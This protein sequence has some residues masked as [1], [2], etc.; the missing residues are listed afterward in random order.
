MDKKQIQNLWLYSNSLFLLN[1]SLAILSLFVAFP[2]PKLPSFFNNLFLI[3]SYALTFQSLAANIKSQG[4]ATFLTKASSQPNTFCLALFL[5]FIPNILLLPFYV[6]CIYHICSAVLSRKKEFENYF[7]YEICVALGKNLNSIGRLALILELTMAPLCVILLFARY[8]S[9]F[10][11]IA[12]FIM[13]RRQCQTNKAMKDV[14]GEILHT[15][16]GILSKMPENY[17]NH[18]NSAIN[19]CK[20]MLKVEDLKKKVE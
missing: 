16:H 6:L 7:F 5:T 11:L 4:I 10:S 8:I 18:L 15:L 9:I 20:A 2:V 12:Y 17:K 14:L 3:F 13:V 1:Y 19:K